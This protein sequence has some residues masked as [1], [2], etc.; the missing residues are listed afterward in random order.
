MDVKPE[1]HPTGTVPDDAEAPPLVIDLDDDLALDPGAAGGKAAALARA[2]RAG[3]R[4]LPATVITT[5]ASDRYDRGVPVADLAG[6][7]RALRLVTD[8]QPLVARSSSVV[9]DQA[10][11]SRAGQFETVLDVRGPDAL[12]RAV[13]V[14]FDSRTRAGAADRPIAVLVQPMAHPTV[15]GVAFGVDPVSGRSDRRVVVAVHGQG[16]P[17]VSGEVDGSRWLLDERGRAL[18]SEI[19]DDVTLP[20][21]RL[22]EVVALGERVAEVFG[23]P[24][25]IEWGLVD[26]ELILFQSR[27]VT[28]TIRGVPSGP[29]FGPGPVAETFPEPLARLEVDLWVPPLR[30]GLREA[31]SI[32]GAVSPR[33]LEDRDLVAVVG[34]RVAI[35]LEV[36]GE[37]D[38][39]SAKR[40]RGG[41]RSRVRRL[42][43]A[44]RIGRLRAALP[45]IAEDLAAQVDRDLDAVPALTELSTRQLVAL[46]DR[47]RDG[48]RSLHAHEIL[49]GMVMEGST[50]GFTGASVALRVLA[51]SRADGCTDEQILQRSPVVLALLPPRIGAPA[52]LPSSDSTAAL[53]YDPPPASQA[54]VEREALRLRAR[55]MQELVGQAAFEIGRRLAA[56][57]QLSEATHVR[58]LRFDELADIVAH[59]SVANEGLLSA[60]AARD[61]AGSPGLPARF[62][63]SDRHLPVAVADPSR[64]SGG[65][66]AGGGRGTGPVTHDQQDPPQGS[67][68]VVSTLSPQLGPILPRLAGLV[69]ETGSVLSHLAILAREQGVP[70]VVAYAGAADLV[71]G[72]EVSVDG[73]SGE[74]A[75]SSGSGSSES[76]GEVGS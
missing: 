64:P 35:D 15:S 27:P 21:A 37:H 20:P 16:D 75:V 8:G 52:V 56:R 17:L 65:T 62:R 50:T 59:R 7:D 60:E 74:V 48:L 4:T 28:S 42:L 73:Q 19:R 11:S 33:V 45:I 31:L 14:V 70:T 22:R 41:L 53:A 54:A 61:R 12:V 29:V 32:S 46:I 63:L 68:L 55:W 13:Q 43:T 67:V 1:P 23:G 72:A 57:G 26:D 39:G 51:E 18:E 38:G 47:G 24:Q 66:G 9:E 76:N 25:D 71:D 49:M 44:W 40:L 10:G 3:V 30:D 34:G 69:A 36:T 2:H 6:I 58:H 5:T